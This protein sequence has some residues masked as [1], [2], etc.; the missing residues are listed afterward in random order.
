MGA[1][2]EEPSHR[3]TGAGGDLPLSGRHAGRS[4]DSASTA[5]GARAA[6]PVHRGADQ[7]GSR[8]APRGDRDPDASAAASW[9]EAPTRSGW[10]PD[11]G[12]RDTGRNRPRR[13]T[14]DRPGR[15]RAD[16]GSLHGAGGQQRQRAGAQAS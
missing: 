12:S 16:V 9:T 10:V 14:G 2:A 11:P 3:T 4:I 13:S 1:V 6:V 8:Q 15:G 7:W 5:P